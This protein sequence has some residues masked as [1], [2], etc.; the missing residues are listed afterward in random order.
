VSVSK[1]RELLEG[2]TTERD[3]LTRHKL[4]AAAIGEGLSNEPVVVGGTAEDHY[5]PDEYHEIDL[6]LCGSVTAEDDEM[7]LSLGFLRE[8]RH[9]FHPG[10][11]VAVEFPESRIDG[12]EG[13]IVRARIRGSQIAIIGVDDLYLNRVRQATA[14]ETGRTQEFHSA[15]AIASANYEE[16]DWP[17]IARRIKTEADGWVR[18]R[19]RRVDSAVRTI[20]RRRLS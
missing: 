12:D 5:T 1:A 2:A 8:G 17:Y 15:V 16:M 14:G 4:V 20:I 11:Q 10:P 19:I 7:L 18:T 9:W 6:D 3:R 13:R